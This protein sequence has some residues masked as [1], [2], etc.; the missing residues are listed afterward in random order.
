LDQAVAEAARALLDPLTA[1]QRATLLTTALADHPTLRTLRRAGR[2]GARARV[3]RTAG[4][5]R[6][7]HPPGV[8]RWS[9]L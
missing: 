6:R 7:V 4:Q 5:H 3:V 9:V 8:L 2:A 1:V